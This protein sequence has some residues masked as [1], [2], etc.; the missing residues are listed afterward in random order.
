[1]SRKKGIRSATGEKPAGRPQVPEAVI[2]GHKSDELVADLRTMIDSARERAAAAVNSELVMLYW[3]IGERIRREILRGR[4][5]EYGKQIVAAVSRQLTAEYG[6]GF[7]SKSLM[8]MVRFAEIFPEAEIVS[9]L[10]RQLSWSHFLEIIYLKDPLQRDFY[11]EMCRIE[12][13]ST[14]TLRSK[15]RGMLY[16]RTAISRKPDALAQKE[17]AALRDEDCMS[18]D[19]V[20]RD[21][22][23]LDF[24]GLA[25]SFS[26]KDFEQ[27]IIVELQ[28]FILEL[29]SDF[30]FIA[31][32]KRMTIGR[33]DFYLDLLFFHRR[34]NCL[35]AVELKLGRFSAA[36]K[37][38]MELYLRWLEKHERRDHEEPLV[39]LIFCSS[40][41]HE[42]VEM[43]QL[44]EG[45][46]RVAEYLTELPPREVLQNRLLAARKRAMEL[47][48]GV[49]KK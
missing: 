4:R 34:L 36:F 6:R 48:S 19:L 49:E 47:V 33:E 35:V 21:S 1:M 24:I 9:A 26:E 44:G 5:A 7:A 12:K 28:R 43:L 38:Q 15:I 22:Y 11:I 39:G 3:G 2:P 42:Q 30:S 20:F 17:L 10:P 23:I 27:A 41:D 14:R 45:E 31:R 8:H 46:I 25:D 18:P 29:G 32:Q 16:E 40:K 13:W 37:G